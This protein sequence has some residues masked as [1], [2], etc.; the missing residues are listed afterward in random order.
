MLEQTDDQPGAFDNYMVVKDWGAIRNVLRSGICKQRTPPAQRTASD[1]YA[2]ARYEHLRALL[3][4]K[5]VRITASG[6]HANAYRPGVRDTRGREVPPPPGEGITTY[7]DE[8]LPWLAQIV[9][10][11]AFFL[12]G[13]WCGRLRDRPCAGAHPL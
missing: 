9:S 6:G 8:Y 5:G 12:R 4:A 7:R 1:T 2:I 13:P 10:N 3:E 11:T